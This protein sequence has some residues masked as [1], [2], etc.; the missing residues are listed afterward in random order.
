[1]RDLFSRLL[2]FK[3]G[4]VPLAVTAALFYFFVLCG[5]GFL[6]PTREAMGVSRGMDDLHMLWLG[7]LVVSLVVVLAF[8]D[9]VSRV[10]RRRFIP[11]GY[12]F[13]IVCLGIFAGL[14]IADAAAGGGLIGTD[15][16]TTV[17]IGVGYTYYVWLS[18]INLFIQALFWAF[19]VDVFDSDQGKRMF[20]F[21]GIGG[22]LGAIVGGW[23]TNTI[24]GM[25]D[26]V[27]LPAGLMLVGAAFF[28]AAIVA[29]L[30]LDRMAVAS[31]YSRLRS[32]RPTAENPKGEKIGGSF[33]DGLAS[34]ARSPYLIGIG[35]YIMLMAVSNTL[36]YFT[37]ANVILENT[38]TFSQRV[39]SF[40]AFDMAAQI[41]TLITQMFITTHLIRKLGVGWTLS[42]LPLVTLAGFAV[43]AIWPLYGVMM[44]FAALHRATRYAVSRPARE[45]L[46]SVVSPAEKYK[47]KPVIDV[48]VYRLGDFVGV[49]LDAGLRVIGLGL[50][51]IAGTVVP[52]AAGWIVL[53]LG[54]GRAQRRRERASKEAEPGSPAQVA[55]SGPVLPA[56]GVVRREET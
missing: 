42:M 50:A 33:W 1:V 22:T 55:G 48:F 7:S 45:T 15:S 54:L 27:Y 36:I 18:V 41:A 12:L 16:E 6:R 37:Q 47:A 53:C 9:V 21:I 24:S 40:A 38:D 28:G 19:M 17:S 29:M 13:V 51:G 49:G 30:T 52:I 26:S 8:G 25:T 2:N 11:I 32:D 31:E 20:A 56:G 5:Y 46:F 4:E 44:V 10:D 35:G 3:R 43:L 14:L 23:A 34:I 39:G